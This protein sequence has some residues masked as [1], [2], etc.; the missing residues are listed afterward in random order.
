MSE[1]CPCA[2]LITHFNGACFAGA[3]SQP[4]G[5]RLDSGKAA[6]CTDRRIEL[7]IRAD[8]SIAKALTALQKLGAQVPEDAGGAQR[9]P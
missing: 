2:S 7:E 4:S 3:S 9:Q 1:S 8:D 5:P 6:L